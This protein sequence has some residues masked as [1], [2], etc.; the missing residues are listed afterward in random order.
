MDEGAWQAV[1]HEIAKNQTRL[2]DFTFTFHFQALQKEMATYSSILAWKNPWTE[3]PDGLQSMGPQ[4]LGH[5]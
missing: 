3:E 5:N 2:K 1:V 4:R